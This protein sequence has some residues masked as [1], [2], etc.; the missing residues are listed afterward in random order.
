MPED[1]KRIFPPWI[2]SWQP[3]SLATIQ[4]YPIPLLAD[5]HVCMHMCLHFCGCSPTDIYINGCLGRGTQASKGSCGEERGSH[6]LTREGGSNGPQ[7]GRRHF[8]AER[9]FQTELYWYHTGLKKW[10]LDFSET[11]RTNF[12]QVWCTVTTTSTLCVCAYIY[13][14]KDTNRYIH[15]SNCVNTRQIKYTKLLQN[16]A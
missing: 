10:L 15:V 13:T 16:W 11:S 7:N 5:R 12:P 6:F 1:S 2:W 8:Q 3:N 4:N 14:H 9:S